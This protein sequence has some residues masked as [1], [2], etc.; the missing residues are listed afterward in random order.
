MVGR[1]SAG[2]LAEPRDVAG[3]GEGGDDASELP[4]EPARRLDR[5]RRGG[6]ERRPARPGLE[7]VRHLVGEHPG[8]Q[9]RGKGVRLEE[10]RAHRRHALHLPADGGPLDR[11]LGGRPRNPIGG[12]LELADERMDQPAHPQPH[13]IGGDRQVGF[14]L[15]GH[16]LAARPHG[17]AGRHHRQGQDG[18]ERRRRSRHSNAS[19]VAKT[20]HGRLRRSSLGTLPPWRTLRVPAA[21]RSGWL[22]RVRLTAPSR[23]A[24]AARRGRR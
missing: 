15:G 10:R 8:V 19:I 23:R 2:E 6:A 21:A 18:D 13:L 1:P 12:P 9:D 24:A 3:A 11:G 7:V 4:F 5:D 22:C 20:A 14:G 16:W 17:T